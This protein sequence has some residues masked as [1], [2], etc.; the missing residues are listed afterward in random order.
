MARGVLSGL[1][2]AD[3]RAAALGRPQKRKERRP[4]PGRLSVWLTLAAFVVVLS[5]PLLASL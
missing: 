4:V 2:P 1:S 3:H 5:A